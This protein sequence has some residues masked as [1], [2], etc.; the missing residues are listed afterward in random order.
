M[1]EQPLPIKTV[2]LKAFRPLMEA[3]Q[4]LNAK[5]AENL[6]DYANR[7]LCSPTDT[8]MLLERFYGFASV[9]ESLAYSKDPNTG[10]AVRR[11]IYKIIQEHGSEP[12]SESSRVPAGGPSEPSP[13]AVLAKPQNVSAFDN[14]E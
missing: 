3:V 9:V 5:D 8:Y 10:D 14:M 6:R 1:I 7:L 12:D 4:P 13:R 2:P 11:I